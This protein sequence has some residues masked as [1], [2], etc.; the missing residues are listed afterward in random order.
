M[1]YSGCSKTGLRVLSL[2]NPLKRLDPRSK[3]LEPKQHTL[4]QRLLQATM[5]FHEVYNYNNIMNNI[6]I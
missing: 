3:T 2:L 5:E 6:I 4:K 1:A